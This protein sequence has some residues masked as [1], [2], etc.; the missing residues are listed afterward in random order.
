M[1]SFELPISV[2]L[3]SEQAVTELPKGL[4]DSVETH[5]VRVEKS[6]DISSNGRGRD[7]DINDRRGMNFAMICGPVNRESPF[8]KRV[9]GVEV[10]ADVTRR[11]FTTVLV[12]D[13]EWYEGRAS[14][15]FETCRDW[16]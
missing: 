13:A 4:V 7:V 10:G 8:Y 9:R 2:N 15:V 11:H 16:G 5:V 12:P 14:I 6:E 1:L 3:R